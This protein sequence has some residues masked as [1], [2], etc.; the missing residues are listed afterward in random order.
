MKAQQ[1]AKKSE[2]FT[3]FEQTLRNLIAVPKSEI[4]E[5]KAKYERQRVKEGK[6]KRPAK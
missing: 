2:E 1:P 6:R 3:R 5:Q 4:D